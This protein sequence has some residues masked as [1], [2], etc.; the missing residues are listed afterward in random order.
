MRKYGIAGK[1][2]IQQWGPP[3][4]GLTWP[5]RYSHGPAEVLDLRDVDNLVRLIVAVAEQP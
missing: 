3:N 5:G 2:S 4:I 1:M